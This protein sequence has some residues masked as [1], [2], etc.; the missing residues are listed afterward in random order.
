ML[1]PIKLWIFLIKIE[2][3]P[4]PPVYYSHQPVP[5][6]FRSLSLGRRNEWAG[7]RGGVVFLNRV[8]LH[9][10]QFLVFQGVGG[11]CVDG[12]MSVERYHSCIERERGSVCV[13]V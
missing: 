4:H 8:F 11:A 9:L 2:I 6:T 3:K 1:A 7:W 10:N 12:N 13:C 5:H